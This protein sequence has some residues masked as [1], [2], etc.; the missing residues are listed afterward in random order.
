MPLVAVVFGLSVLYL[1]VRHRP[2]AIRVIAAAESPLTTA[3]GSRLSVGLARR[4]THPSTGR[5][6]GSSVVA[7]VATEG[8]VAAPQGFSLGRRQRFKDVWHVEMLPEVP[9]RGCEETLR[10][11]L[12]DP[13]VR[14]V[15]LLRDQSA[16]LPIASPGKRNLVLVK[17]YK[18]AGTTFGGILRTIALAHGMDGAKRGQ[19]PTTPQEPYVMAQHRHYWE[20][21]ARV[22]CGKLGADFV[23]L[24]RQPVSRVVSQFYYFWHVFSKRTARPRS[25]DIIEYVRSYI[26]RHPAHQVYYYGGGTPREVMRRLAF[27]GVVERFDESEL[28]IGRW[29]RCQ[30]RPSG[31]HHC[32]GRAP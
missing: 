25:A 23:A 6:A 7:Q 14:G 11:R 24:V 29:L 4:I 2:D 26:A 20:H 10:Q 22:D 28:S 8:S 13:K 19:M 32:V 3:S 16:A 31:C 1:T 12:K 27:V 15:V 17:A 5:G 9:L 18:V 30:R 21:R